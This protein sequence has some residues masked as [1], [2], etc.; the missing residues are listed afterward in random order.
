M[1]DL[2]TFLQAGCLIALAGLLITAA[3]QD[4][5]TLHIANGLSIAIAALFG[6]WAAAGLVEEAYSFT[7]LGL[8]IAC[9]GALF[10]VGAAA[11]AAGILGGG[12]VKLLAAVGLFAGPAQVVD[13]LLV[14]SI[15]GGLLGVAALAGAPLGPVSGRG[16][17]TLRGRLRGR[18]PYGPAIAVGGLW[19]ATR[20]AIG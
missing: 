3:W 9:A 17:A 20:L 4:F 19:V 2:A 15:T 18:L 8:S 12:D 6:V 1:P 14:T 7:T 13:L 16:A 11:F 5:R 10:L